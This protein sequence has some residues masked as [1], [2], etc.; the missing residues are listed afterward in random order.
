[1][2]RSIAVLFIV[3]G[4]TS[5]YGQFFSDAEKAAQNKDQSVVKNSLPEAEQKAIFIELCTAEETATEK[6][7]QMYS[8]Q[9]IQTPEKRQAQQEK[10]E[11]TKSTLFQLYKEEIAKQ[12]NITL[13]YLAAIA[14]SGKE[15]QW[16]EKP[17]T[18]ASN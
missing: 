13:E 12:H 9:I 17:E 7:M 18:P 16:P 11:Q 5:S 15:K 6:G 14:A 8:I 10:A 4:C 2:K 3:A 1:M